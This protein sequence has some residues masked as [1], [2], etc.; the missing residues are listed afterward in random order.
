MKGL[1]YIILLG[2]LVLL[3]VVFLSGDSGY[4]NLKA[5]Q[6]KYLELK[7]ELEEI[8]RENKRIAKEIELIR[9][10]KEFQ[11]YVVRKEL[12]LIRPNEIFVITEGK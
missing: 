5:N 2:L 6:R 4:L 3:V 7:K 12:N 11:E 9:T 8:K 10:D 1:Q